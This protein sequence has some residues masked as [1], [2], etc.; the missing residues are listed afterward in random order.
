M[1]GRS[2]RSQPDVG[3]SSSSF[4]SFWDQPQSSAAGERRMK[5]ERDWSSL[6]EG[7][8][9]VKLS[10]ERRGDCKELSL[11]ARGLI[12]R[13]FAFRLSTGARHHQTNTTLRKLCNHPNTN[14]LTK[15]RKYRYTNT[16]KKGTKRK[17]FQTNFWHLKCTYTLNIKAN[18]ERRYRYPGK[19]WGWSAPPKSR[20]IMDY[21][22][23]QHSQPN[24]YLHNQCQ[25]TPHNGHHL[26]VP[27][28]PTIV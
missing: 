26:H 17:Y 6:E 16:H 2:K 10:W 21:I 28:C 9:I 24:H 12:H 5:R 15:T 25:T 3:A 11:G 14:T 20:S 4:F 1:R 22:P 19:W 13:P 8:E 27:L 7:E 18:Y 23:T